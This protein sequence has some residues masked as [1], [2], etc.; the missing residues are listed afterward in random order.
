LDFS[1]GTGVDR[2]EARR[3]AEDAVVRIE[4]SL[5][6]AAGTGDPQ[7]FRRAIE[8]I[9]ATLLSPLRESR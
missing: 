7:V 8:G 3:R 9:R 2:A 1:V 4:G 5:I 6:V